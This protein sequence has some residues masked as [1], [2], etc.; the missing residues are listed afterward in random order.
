MDILLKETISERDRLR[1]A[2]LRIVD[3]HEEQ[4]SLF[5]DEWGDSDSARYH[6]E[7]RDFALFHLMNPGASG[8]R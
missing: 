3:H 1:D 6:E 8:E 7:R 5:M 2:L 4:R